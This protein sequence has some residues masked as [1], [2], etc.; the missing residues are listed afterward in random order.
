MR[1]YLADQVP[2]SLKIVRMPQ[3]EALTVYEVDGWA[4][5]I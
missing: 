4:L 3:E 2:D 1:K 5:R